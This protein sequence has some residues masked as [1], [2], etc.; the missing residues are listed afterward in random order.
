MNSITIDPSTIQTALRQFEEGTSLQEICSSYS[1]DE[2]TFQEWR[3]KHISSRESIDSSTSTPS[4]RLLELELKV[5]EL[6]Q[7][8]IAQTQVIGIPSL[9]G[10]YF[11]PL[12]E[13]VYCKGESSQ[14][15]IHTADGKR[16][17]VNR[18]LK[19]CELTLN[20]YGFCRIHK[21]Y[22][23][24]KIH[25]NRL[26]KGIPKRVMMSN[27]EQLEISNGYKDQLSSLLLQV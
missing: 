11:I 19:E 9:Q 16:H 15:S 22:L 26:H 13:I 17:L 10:T 21:S 25:V 23:I 5:T 7:M 1:I 18:T 3:I 8:L 14:S 27:G 2:V 4:L 24:N 12:R 20:L 6:K